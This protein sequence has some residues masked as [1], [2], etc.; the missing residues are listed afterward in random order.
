MRT[1]KSVGPLLCWAL[2]ACGGGAA[3]EWAGTVTDSAGVAIVENPATGIWRGS[4]KWRVEETLRIGTTEGDPNYQFGAIA[5]LDVGEDGT[6]YVLDQQAQQ[7][8]AYDANGVYIRTIGRPGSGPGELSQ[9]AAAVLVGRGDTL[10]VAD[11]M[12]Q[13]VNLYL[14]DGT[15]AGSFPLPMNAGLAVRWAHLPGGRFAHESR[16]IPMA[17]PG[18]QA[19]SSA[20]VVLVRGPDGAVLD[21][22]LRL[23][24]GKTFQ[25]Q[26][27][28]AQI[29]LF[30]PEPVWDVW[31]DGS[32]ASG[33]S[34][35][36]RI[37]IRGPDGR[38]ERIVKRRFERVPVTE[39]DQQAIRQAMDKLFEQQ[40]VPAMIRQQLVQAID[41]ADHYPAFYTIVAGPEWTLW[42]QLGQT[43][44]DVAAAGTLNVQ[45]LGAPEW[46]VFDAN[47]RYLG[48][49]RFPERFRAIRFV[50]ND[51]YGVWRDE[52]D[53]EHVMRLRVIGIGAAD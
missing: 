52:F 43:A 4:S 28:N 30:E 3:G 25:F 1:A 7:V 14:P 2:A 27:G 15:P 36:Y 50:G 31:P 8:R 44:A 5:S 34:T 45:D 32:S 17:I 38:L 23:P 41:F 48:V 33:V 11:G 18:Q 37:E 16:P 21:T 26:G 13:R 46:D 9:A 6:I 47:G 35:D 53:V 12:N 20:H 51:V 19:T 24:E 39:S 42:V 29:R 22:L 40:G 10:Y 49:V